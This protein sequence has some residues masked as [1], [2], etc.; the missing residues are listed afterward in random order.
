MIIVRV[1]LLAAILITTPLAVSGQ[2]G[3]RALTDT[4]GFAQAMGDAYIQD[5]I[6]R[7]F[8]DTVLA[9]TEEEIYS[10]FSVS[11]PGEN[12]LA[13]AALAA[14]TRSI[15]SQ[16]T[17]GAFIKAWTDWHAQL[18][19]DL[20]AIAQGETGEIT[21]VDGSTLTVNATDLATA[22]LSGP[23]ANL[24]GAAIDEDALTQEIDT[25]YDLEADLAALGELAADRWVFTLAAIG[26]LIALILLW[27]PMTTGAA[28]GL[29]AG[30]I[31][32]FAMAAWQLLAEPESTGLEETA[33]GM[34]IGAAF[35][36]GLPVW[37]V[38]F[39]TAAALAAM[40]LAVLRRLRSRQPAD[41]A[42]VATSA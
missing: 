32:C 14:V 7:E 31:G 12:F 4:D 41:P 17:S 6:Y 22:L 11:G 30:S 9:A 37:L 40:A 18:H 28:A 1:L 29:F 13:D 24:A 33:Q 36:A 20:S 2:W 23:L 35:G 8:G 19:R 5:G 16:L 15:E 21:S 25:G 38:S 3:Q 34:A 26:A 27:R 10:R 42:L 39:G